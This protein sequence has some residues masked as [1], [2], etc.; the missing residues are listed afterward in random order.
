MQFVPGPEVRCTRM[1][2]PMWDARET[3][4][5]YSSAVRFQAAAGPRVASCAETVAGRVCKHTK[6]KEGLPLSRRAF[7]FG[8]CVCVFCQ[9]KAVVDFVGSPFRGHSLGFFGG[10]KIGFR[11]KF[12]HGTRASQAQAFWSW[13]VFDPSCEQE[14]SGRAKFGE[15]QKVA[16]PWVT[17]LFFCKGA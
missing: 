17:K 8:K 16:T 7:C 12:S 4:E 1:S 10:R 5:A 3:R 6:H 14:Q 9:R 2:S 13:A 15:S 11:R